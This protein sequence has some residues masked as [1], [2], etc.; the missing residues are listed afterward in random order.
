MASGHLNRSLVAKFATIDRKT[1][2]RKPTGMVCLF[3][4]F[5]MDGWGYVSGPHST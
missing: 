3:G 4:V 2:D 5:G 1:I